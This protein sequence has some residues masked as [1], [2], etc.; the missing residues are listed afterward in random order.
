M[1]AGTPL[2][3]LTGIHKQF[4][5]VHALRAAHLTLRGAGET[6]V[7]HALMGE[8]GSGKSTMLSILSGLIRP[9]TG[10]VSFGG[11]A[12]TL[13]GP[14]DALRHGVAMVSQET[15]VVERLSVAENV[16]LGRRLAGSPMRISWRGTRTRARS[17][18]D[19]LN[20]D[21]D[22][23]WIVADLRP[24][25][26]QMVEIA[27]A[28]SM[29]AKILVLDEPTSHFTDDEVESLFAVIRSLRER[30][31]STIFV[32][33]RLKEIFAIADEVTVLRDGQTVATGPIT[34]FTPETL[35]DAMVGETTGLRGKP[36]GRPRPA[37]QPGRPLLSVHGLHTASGLRDIDVTVDR[38]EIVGLAGLVGAG[39]SDL[40]RAVFGLEDVTAGEISL[41]GEP[42]RPGDT[43]GAIRRGIGFVPADRRSEGAIGSMS[44]NDNLMLVHTMGRPRLSHPPRAAESRMVAQVMRQVRIRAA[45]AAVPV[46]S[47]SGGNQQKVVLG[48]WLV[49]D[50]ALLLLDE[51]T[52]GVDVAGKSEIHQLLRLAAQRG[53][54]LLVSSSENDELLELCDRIAVMFRG[55][56]VTSCT[57]QEADEA[58]LAR[59]AGGHT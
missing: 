6:G 49:S 50:P 48:K 40:L 36:A 12:A 56:I 25:Q 53:V 42:L 18:L 20:L 57:A 33:H 39:C 59:Y 37:G 24:D 9:D 32:S 3:A 13:A 15:A 23:D 31:I 7:V 27:R 47:L 45:S 34:D 51:P 52:R 58:M 21:Y 17:V 14:V 10:T 29:D 38:G 28:L 44:V 41:G 43:R 11:T 2:L 19:R 26:R 1:T 5:G 16:L 30:G 35:V 8:N 4:G 46:G 54:G 22:P 55:R